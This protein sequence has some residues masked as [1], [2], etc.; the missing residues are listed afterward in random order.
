MDPHG[1]GVLLEELTTHRFARALTER[2]PAAN[3][4][5]E[6]LTGSFIPAGL[7]EETPVDRAH[8]NRQGDDAR[9]FTRHRRRLPAICRWRHWHRI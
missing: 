5:M 1:E 8:Q 4:A 3:Q 2:D 6:L 9:P 7:H